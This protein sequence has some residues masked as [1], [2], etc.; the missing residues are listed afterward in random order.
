[1]KHWKSLVFIFLFAFVLNS[2][3]SSQLSL[4]KLGDCNVGDALELYL[5]DDEPGEFNVDIIDYYDLD[6]KP[7]GAEIKV[8]FYENALKDSD[9]T[10]L[11]LAFENSKLIYWGY[12]EDFLKSENEKLRLIGEETADIIIDEFIEDGETQ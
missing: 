5:S 4:G 10:L 8:L 3:S 1:M 7:N 6:Y 12:P 2:Y 9:K 11:V